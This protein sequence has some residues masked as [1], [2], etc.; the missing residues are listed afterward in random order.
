MSF[1]REAVS[2]DM[3]AGQDRCELWERLRLTGFVALRAIMG[4]NYMF[5]GRRIQLYVPD[6][7][8]FVLFFLTFTVVAEYKQI[9]FYSTGETAE[10]RCVCFFFIYDTN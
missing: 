9:Y 10:T 5:V 1:E 2:P 8:F 6:G 4:S 3:E 7:V